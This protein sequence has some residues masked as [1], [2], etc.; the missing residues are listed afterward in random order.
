MQ[1]YCR[2]HRQSYSPFSSNIPKH[3]LLPAFILI[4][5][6]FVS[7]VLLFFCEAKKKH[8]LMNP[9]H[10]NDI[11]DN[12][13]TFKTIS[14]RFRL[15]IFVL[16]FHDMKERKK[17]SSSFINIEWRVLIFNGKLTKH[18]DSCHMKKAK[19]ILI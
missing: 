12:F 10:Q 5:S 9:K 6:S 11:V 13:N 19:K 8:Y 14:F 4:Y 15:K 16:W 2:H 17:K 7:I 3:L 1:Q 18:I